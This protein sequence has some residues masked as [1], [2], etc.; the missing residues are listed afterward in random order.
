M[1]RVIKKN[2]F[3]AVERQILKLELPNF[4]WSSYFI[5]H[6]HVNLANS[7]KPALEVISPVNN[8]HTYIFHINL[9]FFFG[10]ENHII[11]DGHIKVIKS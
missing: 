5:L 2:C 11:K 6:E 8:I 4:R 3:G 9:V 10:I 1:Y 7:L